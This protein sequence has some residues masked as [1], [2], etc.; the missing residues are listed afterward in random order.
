M[1]ERTT[2]LVVLHTSRRSV[3]PA[4][5]VLVLQG[6]RFVNDDKGGYMSM[7]DGRS[8]HFGYY[9]CGIW[10]DAEWQ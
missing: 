3:M 10:F 8:Y 5:S 1:N 7:P 9:A 4:R 2:A 6:G